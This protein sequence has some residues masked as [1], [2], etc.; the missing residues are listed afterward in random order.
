[1]RRL[2]AS[3]PRD[4]GRWFSYVGAVLVA[5]AGALVSLGI[6]IWR[7]PGL[8]SAIAMDHAQVARNLFEGR[9]F[10][11]FF[12]RPLS[13]QFH[14]GGTHHPDLVNA[15]LHPFLLALWYC[16]HLPTDRST[17]AFGA[18]VW[19]A[20]LGLTYALARRWFGTRIAAVATLL[21]AVNL[22][23]VA[24][25]ATGLPYVLAAPAVLVAIWLVAPALD[26]PESMHRRPGH[27][28]PDV[29]PRRLLAA[30][31]AC[32][33]AVLTAYPLAV[34]ALAVAFYLATCQKQRGRTVAWFAGGFFL[35]L[36]PWMLRNLVVAGHPFFS[37]SFYEALQNTSVFPGDS[38]W[39][40][41]S[42]RPP[43]PLLFVLSHP[44]EMLAKWASSFG[45]FFLGAGAI[46]GP[47]AVFLFLL[48]FCS[49][50]DSRRWR[51]L[52]AAAAGSIALA[53]VMSGLLRPDPALLV[54][55][56]PLVAIVAAA[57]LCRWL[58]DTGYHFVKRRFSSPMGPPDVGRGSIAVAGSALVV[59]ISALP[60]VW[61]LVKGSSRPASVMHDLLAGMRRSVPGNAVVATDQPTIVSWY[62]AR[63][64]VWLCRDAR[65]WDALARAGGTV[66]A[67]YVSE[68]LQRQAAAGDDA[69]WEWLASPH[70]VYQLLGPARP[71]PVGS[72]LRLRSQPGMGRHAWEASLRMIDRRRAEVQA[73]PGSTN[74]RLGLA[75]AYLAADRLFEADGEYRAVLRNDFGNVRGCLG[76]S[77]IAGRMGHTK[78]AVAFARRARAREGNDPAIAMRLADA[79]LAA[80]KDAEAF[81]VLRQAISAHPGSTELG[82]AAA[83]CQARRGNWKQA[84]RLCTDA[85][86]TDRMSRP[87]RVLLGGIYLNLGRT[88]EARTTWQSLAR[89]KPAD[90]EARMLAGRALRM[91]GRYRES[92]K[93]LDA[94]LA[95]DPTYVDASLEAA[96]ACLALR[97]PDR[98]ATYLEKA[99]G[100]DSASRR[101]LCGR[102]EVYV[103]QGNLETALGIYEHL[104]LVDPRDGA[105][106]NNL[107][108]LC[109]DRP[110]KKPFAVRSARQLADLNPNDGLIQD[111]Y[112]W[113]CYRTGQTGEAIKAFRAA[114]RLAP[115]E[116]VIRYHLGKLLL[117][118]GNRA[119]GQRELR[120]SLRM[121]ILPQDRRDAEKLLAGT[122]TPR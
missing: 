69:S 92:L 29:A 24:A 103:A 60:L 102:A 99:L 58:E 98:A 7:F 93:E 13:L 72:L 41:L 16:V 85:L 81:S 27:G 77:T 120:A 40:E 9:G 73:N 86:R 76:I 114:A 8:Q 79:L 121:A 74:A 108:Y 101:A 112:G 64:A 65:E 43:H 107:V 18:L 100:H 31:I 88:K 39:R 55:W 54:A 63:R 70:G 94:A 42:T 115:R 20:T 28:Q 47:T 50:R 6:L 23:A 51:W 52:M 117:E 57:C 44:F 110:D 19:M 1:M 32:A 90:R 2:I 111:T 30:G 80:G 66:A 26:E 83:R 11:T 59:A 91:E 21:C 106:L 38:V 12:I 14:S 87:G 48:S 104:L 119:E 118:T 67:S 5:A 56:T 68:N 37:L 96:Q 84:E 95:Q 97:E 17:G 109:A 45:R 82:L 105:A 25:A 116:G 61:F 49:D 113:V 89:E 62:G 122:G 22:A 33:L 36:A 53:S 3:A 75:D 78:D 4:G 71:V 34:F 35:A 15:P 46:L 10:S